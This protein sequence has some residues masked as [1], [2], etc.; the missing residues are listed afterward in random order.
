[1]SGEGGERRGE[2]GDGKQ[3]RRRDEE[4]TATTS[5]RRRREKGDS[6]LRVSEGGTRERENRYSQEREEREKEERK[7][8][9]TQQTEGRQRES[10]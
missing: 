9:L 8:G 3:N 4:A 1:M 5:D 2:K 7:T 6:I 10:E